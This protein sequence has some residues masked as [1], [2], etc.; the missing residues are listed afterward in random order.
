MPTLEIGEETEFNRSGIVTCSVGVVGELDEDS[1]PSSDW[2]LVF[3]FSGCCDVSM[4]GTH[5]F[6]G[7]GDLDSDSDPSRERDPSRE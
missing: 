7:V 5:D 1:D 2:V 4:V 3:L 6:V